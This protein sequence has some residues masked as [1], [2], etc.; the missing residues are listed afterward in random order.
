MVAPHVSITAE[1]LRS[2]A[3]VGRRLLDGAREEIAHVE[4]VLQ[5]GSLRRVRSDATLLAN[6]SAPGAVLYSGAKPG[7]AYCVSTRFEVTF[8]ETLQVYTIAKRPAFAVPGWRGDARHA[9]DRRTPRRGAMGCQ[10][11]LSLATSITPAK[12]ESA[13][14]RSSRAAL[15]PIKPGRSSQGTRK[16][17]GCFA[18]SSRPRRRRRCAHRDRTG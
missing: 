1:W 17:A 18:G 5:A 14:R 10:G 12:T 7:P 15:D 4:P 2:A 8:D 3:P 6:R 9:T 16:Q 13:M 11:K